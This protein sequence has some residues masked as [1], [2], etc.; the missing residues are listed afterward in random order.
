MAD[1]LEQ[2]D[3]FGNSTIP[4]Q[5]ISRDVL[6]KRLKNNLEN[7]SIEDFVG[8]IT[9]EFDEII[10]YCD[11]SNGE[12]SC[13]KTSLLFNPHRLNTKTKTSKY[14]IFEALKTESFISGL[15]RAVLF[16]KGKV[17]E[18]LYQVMQLGINGIQYVNEFPPFVARNIMI[19]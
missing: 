13:Q 9:N 19:K 8:L 16:K 6:A 1:G 5:P 3:L 7:I 11:L 10:E 17:S 2:K 15:A 18:L 14:S 4:K 12:K